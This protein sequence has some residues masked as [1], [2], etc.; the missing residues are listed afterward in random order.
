MA[1]TYRTTGAWGAGIGVNLSA[2][3][4]DAN[5][6]DLDQRVVELETN[7]EPPNGISN[8]TVSGSQLTIYTSDLTQYGPFTIPRIPFQPSKVSTVSTTTHTP[9][10]ADANCYK[11]C[12]NIDGCAITIPPFADVAYTVD[13]ELTFVAAAIAGISFLEGTGVTINPVEGFEME[14]GAQGAVITVKNVAE[15]VWDLIGGPLLPTP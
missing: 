11:R 9:A 1:I 2:A 15:N 4:V 8:I 10:L 6:Y 3:Q 13:T 14:S 5:F 7:P 12:T